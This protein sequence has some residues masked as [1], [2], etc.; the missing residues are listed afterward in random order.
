MF[1]GGLVELQLG[2]MRVSGLLGW[3]CLGA[4]LKYFVEIKI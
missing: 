2:E 3:F 4:F 1:L